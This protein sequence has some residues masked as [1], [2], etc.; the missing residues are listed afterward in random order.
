MLSDVSRAM[1]SE[2]DGDERA[3][4]EWTPWEERPLAEC[5]V[6]LVLSWTSENLKLA[7][8]PVYNASGE[9]ESLDLQSAGGNALQPQL[10]R[11]QRFVVALQR[12]LRRGECV[13]VKGFS[14][15]WP[16]Y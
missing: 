7:P 13:T 16:R 12:A 11:P 2:D 3:A 9:G 5:V 10:D 1:R 15:L 6:E 4:A 8:L 14:R